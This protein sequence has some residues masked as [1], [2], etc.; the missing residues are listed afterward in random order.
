MFVDPIRDVEFLQ[1]NGCFVS[2][3]GLGGVEGDVGCFSN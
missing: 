3:G 1:E 2:I